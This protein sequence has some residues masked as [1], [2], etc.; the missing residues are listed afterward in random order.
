MAYMTRPVYNA[1]TKPGATNRCEVEL[2]VVC[3]SS[4]SSLFVMLLF[5]GWLPVPGRFPFTWLCA[6]I[7][8]PARS[9][10][11]PKRLSSCWD[12][13]SL[14][15][16]GKLPFCHLLYWGIVMHHFFVTFF[17]TSWGLSNFRWQ[18]SF[19]T[20]EHSS[21]FRRNGEKT[22]S[23]I[24]LD[25]AVNWELAN[26]V[27]M[28]HHICYNVAVNSWLQVTHLMG[29]VHGWM[30]YKVMTLRLTWKRY[31]THMYMEQQSLQHILCIS[32]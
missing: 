10:I 29:F 23:Y 8:M 11:S 9:P 1:G 4:S 18:N 24:L 31:S 13:T 27:K 5:C 32:M 17:V 7:A 30:N 2:L 22:S 15:G 14:I 3:T 25:Q 6:L 20:S 26:L 12:L 21:T 28:G 16:I 19:G